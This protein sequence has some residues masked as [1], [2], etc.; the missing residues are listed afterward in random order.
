MPPATGGV[1]QGALT[2]PLCTTVVPP[3]PRSHLQ[4][5]Q[6]GCCPA[7][8]PAAVTLVVNDTGQR[9]PKRRTSISKPWKL[10]TGF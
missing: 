7:A 3:R 9:G 1:L 2:A 4:R 10:L 8:V 5:L 6:R